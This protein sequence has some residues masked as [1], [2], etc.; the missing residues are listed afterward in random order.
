MANTCQSV[1]E[2][3]SLFYPNSRLIAYDGI[4]IKIEKRVHDKNPRM[5]GKRGVVAHGGQN[6][7]GGFSGADG[8]ESQ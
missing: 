6:G 8:G 4:H 3:R 2:G 1:L 7:D 5:S